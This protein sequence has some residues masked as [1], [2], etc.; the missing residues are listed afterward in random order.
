MLMTDTDQPKPSVGPLETSAKKAFPFTLACPSFIYPAG[1]VEN[2]RLLAPIVDEIQLLFFESLFSDSLPSPAL[3]RKLARLGRDGDTT[4]NVH[5]PSD[6]HLGHPEADVRRRSVSVLTDLI[7]R[8]EPLDPTT[9]TLHLNRDALM[10]DNERWQAYTI[11]SL[12]A[13]LAAGI[14][15][16]L[17]SVENLAYDFN[18]AAPVVEGLDLSVCM[19][20]GHLMA[21]G[22]AT[23]P[24]FERWQDR[25]TV[26]HLHGVDG[27]KDHL[28]LNRLAPAHMTKAMN[29]LQR[30]GGVV[31]LEVYSVAAL[32]ASMQHL[33]H[34][35]LKGV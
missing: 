33:L 19:D 23:R 7:A 10:A 1:Y 25:I 3:I 18:L 8:C 28:P 26:V 20:M 32:N 35:W 13:V 24:F 21:H 16:R 14:S 11:A 9:F 6:I 34:Q 5:L 30:F 12:E 29:L 31:S 4:F 2:V 22:Q 15:S 27:A 17:I